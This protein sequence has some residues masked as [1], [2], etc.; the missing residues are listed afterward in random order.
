MEKLTKIKLITLAFIAI[1]TAIIV[2]VWIG[3]SHLN[4]INKQIANLENKLASSTEE[5][6]LNISKNNK[7]LVDEINSQ[8]QN[9]G[10]IESKLGIYQKEV[11]DFSTTVNNLQ[12]LSKTDPELLAKYSKVFFLNENYAPARIIEIPNKYKYLDSKI[13]KIQTDT[14]PFL[15]KMIDNASN[16]DIPI[17]VDSA[18]RSFNEQKALKSGYKVV[19]GAGTSNQ[20]SADQG[21]SEHQLG[22]TVDLLT[23]GIDG[24]IDNFEGTKAYTWLNN[25]AYHF[26]FVLSYPKDNKFYVF[27]PWHWRFVG[28]KLATDLHNQNKTFYDMDQRDIDAYLVSIFD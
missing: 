18:Y 2:F 13:L 21:Y 14:W 6:N 15:Q 11:G 27:E 9:I 20:F 23:S 28:V 22:T 8:R 26:G 12:K 19:Y 3:Y 17:Y 1:I 10:T 16:V 5:L 7:V 4:L 24:N 25:N